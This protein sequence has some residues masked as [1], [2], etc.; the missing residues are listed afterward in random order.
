MKG[1]LV[2]ESGRAAQSAGR[3]SMWA[4][5]AAASLLAKVGRPV[6]DMLYEASAEVGEWAIRRRRSGVTSCLE[7]KPGTVEL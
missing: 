3:A 1:S 7:S 6:M 4:G 5:L 2:V